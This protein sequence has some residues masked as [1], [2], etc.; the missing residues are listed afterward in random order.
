MT[1]ANREGPTF[2]KPRAFARESGL[3]E[4]FVRKM[5]ADGRLKYIKSGRDHYIPRAEMARLAALDS[6][7]GEDVEGAAGVSAGDGEKKTLGPD[8]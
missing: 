1:T 7:S 2:L 6:V 5:L 4:L 8:Q 3:A